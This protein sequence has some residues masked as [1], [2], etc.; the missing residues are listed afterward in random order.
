MAYHGY[1]NWTTWNVVLWFGNDEGLYNSVLDHR[2]RFTAAKAKDFV[3][4][5]L[6][7][8]T[9]DMSDLSPG[10]LHTAY[11]EVSWSEVAKVFNEMKGD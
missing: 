5:E 9:P 10:K 8:G 11:G 7:K 4:E 2:G 6:P 3:L 1:K